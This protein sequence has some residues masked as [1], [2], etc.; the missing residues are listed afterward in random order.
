MPGE[1]MVEIWGREVWRLNEGLRV[2]T[3]NEELL[4]LEFE[5]PE[6]ANRVLVSGRRN[7]RGGALQLERL[8]PYSGCI[9]S[10]GSAQEE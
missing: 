2:A 7:F 5:S 10:K 4:F 8:N 6:E 1:K 9:R 3:L